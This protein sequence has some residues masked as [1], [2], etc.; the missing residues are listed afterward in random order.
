LAKRVVVERTFC[1]AR[2]MNGVPSPVLAQGNDVSAERNERTSC[3][4]PM[5]FVS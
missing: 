4:L 1:F 3:S 5:Q 2:G